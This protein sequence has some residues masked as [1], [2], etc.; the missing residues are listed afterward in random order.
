MIKS[1]GGL[2]VPVGSESVLVGKAEADA[3]ALVLA[4][5][6]AWR[7]IGRNGVPVPCDRTF[8]AGRVNVRV[9]GGIVV[10]A[11]AG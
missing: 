3:K 11:H 4:S 1:T 5:W 6:R 7:V 8:D 2:S 10:E 9:D